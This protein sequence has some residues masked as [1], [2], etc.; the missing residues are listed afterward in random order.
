MQE[1]TMVE[2][3][4]NV[5]ISQRDV[6][7]N[8]THRDTIQMRVL[9]NCEVHVGFMISTMIVQNQSKRE[10]NR[11]Y[12]QPLTWPRIERGVLCIISPK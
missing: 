9:Y 8:D 7:G 12:Q 2:L 10:K 1:I 5:S 6:V 4:Y 3:N 11:N